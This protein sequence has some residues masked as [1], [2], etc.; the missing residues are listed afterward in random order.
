MMPDCHGRPRRIRG[1]H[2]RK[3]TAIF[4][5]KGVQQIMLV[6][7]RK[8]DESV[9]IGENGEIVVTVVEVRGDKVRLGFQAAKEIPV[10]RRE[11]WMAIQQ[12]DGGESQR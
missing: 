10:H 1:Q 8:R 4:S 2:G 6:L 3:P 11:V 7:S 9:V 5:R 12:Q